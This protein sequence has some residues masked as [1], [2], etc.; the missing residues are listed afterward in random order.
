MQLWD[1]RVRKSWEKRLCRLKV[2][3]EREKESTPGTAVDSS[4]AHGEDQ[5]GADCP[6]SAHRGP[7]QRGYPHCNLWKT[8]CCS[9]WM[10]PE[11]SCSPWRGH[12]G[13]S[14]WQE[15]WLT[16]DWHWSSLFQ[17]DY[18]LWKGPM[19]SEVQPVR[20]NYVGA[21][22]EGQYPR[23]GTPCWSRGATWRGMSSRDGGLWT[24][25]NPYPLTTIA[26]LGERGGRRVR[27]EEWSWA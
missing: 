7:C 4:A 14:S 26:L 8:P 5:D 11:G 10:C 6:S 17:M 20:R 19:G 21:V 13:A 3:G 9:R 22:H 24:D 12:I 16:R 15:L 18:T 23:G 2:S 1:R 27:N 25:C